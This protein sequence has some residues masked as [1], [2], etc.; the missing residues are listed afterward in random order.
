MSYLRSGKLRTH[1]PAQR[2]FAHA[3]W[4][5]NQHNLHAVSIIQFDAETFP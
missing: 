3:G 4:P 5:G 2:G 1:F